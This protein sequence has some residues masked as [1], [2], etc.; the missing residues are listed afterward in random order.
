MSYKPIN[1][2][3]T[4]FEQTN[5]LFWGLLVLIC[6]AGGTYLL[7]GSFISL[8]WDF[9]KVEQLLALV[10]FV[11]SFWGIIKLSEPPYNFL[12]YFKDKQLYIEIKKGNLR[13]K[14]LQIPVKE[15]EELKFTPHDPRSSDEALFDFSANFHLLYRKKD[16]VSFQKLLGTESAAITLKVDDIGKIMHFITDHNP[17]IMI[18]QEQAQYF[19]L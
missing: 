13:T 6:T 11:I 14:T 10:L 12:L 19:S 15:I 4:V 8:N 1:S 2:K 5:N 3:I 9:F 17:N 18:P 7:A 16:D